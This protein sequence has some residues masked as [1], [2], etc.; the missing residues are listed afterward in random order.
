MYVDVYFFINFVVDLLSLFAVGRIML[1]PI[2]RW[3]CIFAA[4]VGATYSV[5]HFFFPLPMVLH[6]AAAVIM[7]LCVICKR[8]VASVALSVVVFICCEA[9]IGGCVTALQE[10]SSLFSQMSILLTAFIILIAVVGSNIFSVVQHLLKKRLEE[11]SLTAR[12]WHR[13]KYSELILMVDSGNLVRDPTTKKRV[14][15]VKAE[16]IMHSIGD[17]DTIFERERCY[18]IPIDT[19]SGRG[20]VMGFV[21]D[22]IEFSDKKY[23]EQEF[24][25]VPDIHGGKF[26]GYDGIAPLI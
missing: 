12:L 20:A 18:V 7:V 2:S 23:N 14:V 4:T 15:F 9:F 17:A 25:V 8:R 6:I 24:I 26:G 16:S 3:R 19:A 1:F 13:G 21:P 11:L 10:L 5:V 22:R